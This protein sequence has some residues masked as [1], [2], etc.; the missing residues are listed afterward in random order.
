MSLPDSTTLAAWGERARSI[1]EEAGRVLLAGYRTGDIVAEHKG[2]I[3]LVTRYDRESEALI[4][5]RMKDVFPDH[6]VVAEEG[7]A[8]GGRDRALV[9]FCDPLDGTTNFA[10]GHFVFAVAIGLVARKENGALVPL[11]GAVHA[12]VLDVTWVGGVGVPSQRIERGRTSLCALGRAE[13]LA[14]A[15]VATGFPYDRRASLENNVAEHGHVVRLVRGVRRCGSAAIDLCL[16]ADGTYDGYWEQ[17]L[18]PWDLAAGAAI[19]VGAGAT[20]TDYDGGTLDV[21][22]GRVVATNGRIHEELRA[23]LMEARARA[24]LDAR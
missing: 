23:A 16:V 19:A 8:Q 17:K 5:A 1:A 4:R 3:D 6:D 7:G 18:A 11:V 2:A 20:L 12:P 21:G 15:L 24:G 9:W 14:N 10:H 13:S 22:R